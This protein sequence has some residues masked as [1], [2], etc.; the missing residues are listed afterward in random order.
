MNFPHYRKFHIISPKTFTVFLRFKHKISHFRATKMEPFPTRWICKGESRNLSEKDKTSFYNSNKM[1][2]QVTWKLWQGGGLEKILSSWYHSLLYK[3]LI[4][5]LFFFEVIWHNAWFS[6][7]VWI[8]SYYYFSFLILW[9]CQTCILSVKKKK[10][11]NEEK[12]VLLNGR[13]T[14][15]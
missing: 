4:R 10:K 5:R 13:V 15:F 6:S 14:R 11:R 9:V 7:R 2:Y 1:F 8:V 3:H 12:K